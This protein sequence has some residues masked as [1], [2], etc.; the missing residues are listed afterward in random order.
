MIFKRN[1]FFILGMIF[2]HKFNSQN[3]CNDPICSNCDPNNK[4][5]CFKCFFG[6]FIYKNKCSSNVCE[7]SNCIK[8]EVS[9]QNCLKCLNLC[10]IKEGKCNCAF[11]YIII[12][13]LVI[14]L[15]FFTILL[16]YRY[17]KR[18]KINNQIHQVINNIN[19]YN[20]TTRNTKQYNEKQLLTMFDSNKLS[21][22]IDKNETNKELENKICDYCHKNLC[23]LKLNCNHFIC[24]ECNEKTLLNKENK[25]FLCDTQI[26]NKQSIQC[27]ICLT[28]NKE[29][30]KFSCHCEFL[31]CKDCFLKYRKE[32]SICPGCRANLEEN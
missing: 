4:D 14:F 23:A 12:S 27:G 32:N 15:L 10:Y 5:K 28:N 29:L 9:S 19:I 16:I 2:M 1:C 31:I 3:L 8:C 6:F 25:C 24:K 30:T 26:T 18:Q 17:K 21:L 13:I 20:H 7:N 22:N 11:K